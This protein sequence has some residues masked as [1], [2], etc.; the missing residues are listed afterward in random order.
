MFAFD[1]SIF[2][3][4]DRGGEFRQL[5]RFDQ[6]TGRIDAV[7]GEVPWDVDRIDRSLDRR[8]FA[9]STNE[10]GRGVARIVD[11]ESP[12]VT[13][14]SSPPGTGVTSVHIAPD[15]RRLAYAFASSATPASI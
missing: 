8:V 13:A 7:T 6:Q 14:L 2:M 9:I 5:A 11:A 3:V 4:T 10:N 15:G 1:G 12:R